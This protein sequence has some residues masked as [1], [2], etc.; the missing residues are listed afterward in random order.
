MFEGK[1]S[2]RSSLFIVETRAEKYVRNICDYVGQSCRSLIVIKYVELINELYYYFLL[3]LGNLFLLKITEYRQ[4]C[5]R[6]L[7]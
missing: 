2:G 5:R 3:R 7:N 6:P 1:R 4:N